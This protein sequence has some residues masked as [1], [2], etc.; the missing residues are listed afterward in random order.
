[1]E[2]KGRG[3]GATCKKGILR[4]LTSRAESWTPDL[5]CVGDK[6]GLPKTSRTET[7]RVQMIVKIIGLSCSVA[8]Y[9]RTDGRVPE[10][11]F[12]KINEFCHSPRA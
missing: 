9:S 2:D 1:M 3:T 5:H 10:Q 4:S 7:V 11:Q 8:F 12:V 6:Q